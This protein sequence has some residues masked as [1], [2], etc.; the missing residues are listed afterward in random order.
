M[1]IRLLLTYVRSEFWNKKHRQTTTTTTATKTNEET[2]QKVTAS[3]KV[4]S[5]E[6][7]E[8]CIH[9]VRSNSFY[10]FK[11]GDTSTQNNRQKKQTRTETAE[12]SLFLLKSVVRTRPENEKKRSL[13]TANTETNTRETYEHGFYFLS[14]V[15]YTR[16]IIIHSE[17]GRVYC[18]FYFF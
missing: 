2:I 17:C 11:N 12:Q 13:T 1:G 8:S 16:G 10:R 3:S 9:E 4:K 14:A 6:L 18:V 7:I 15:E 5:L